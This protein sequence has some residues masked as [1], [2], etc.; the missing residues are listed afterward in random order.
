M[1][2]ASARR[3]S[4]SRVRPAALLFGETTGRAVS[5]APDDETAVRAAASSRRVAILGIG[6]TGGDRLRISLAGRPLIDESA[7]ELTQTWRGAFRN[8]IES[9]DLL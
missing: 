9:A 8:A 4:S 6:R 7:G 1:Q 3:S 2:G 5:F